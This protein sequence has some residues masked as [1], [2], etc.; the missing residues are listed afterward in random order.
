MFRVDAI[1]HS[2]KRRAHETAEIIGAHLPGVPLESSE[3]ADD[4]TPMPTDLSIVP[5]RYRSF[6]SRV[7]PAERDVDSHQL[8]AAIDHLARSEPASAG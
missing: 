6:L 8:N 5:D 3:Q 4:R 2:P 1:V 7:P